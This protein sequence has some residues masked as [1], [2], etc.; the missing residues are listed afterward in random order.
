MTRV[1]VV[2]LI[3]VGGSACM[4]GGGPASQAS[5]P[6]AS[7]TGSTTPRGAMGMCPMSVPG[8]QVAAEDTATGEALTF[9]T[10]PDQAGALRERVHAMA[11]MHNQHHSGDDS[12]HV[13]MH[14]MMGGGGGMTMPPPSQAV[15]DDLPQG[16]RMV[17]TPKDPGDLQR[18]Q[19][20]V[21]EHAAR[22]QQHGC[23]MMGDAD[24]GS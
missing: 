24:H 22:M 6:A 18:L 13:G 17:V 1:L 7:P 14:G 8:A 21:R 3:L 19:A 9:T 4:H 20:T 2:S 16:A 5:S 15:V 10:S 23:G 11:Q 12:G